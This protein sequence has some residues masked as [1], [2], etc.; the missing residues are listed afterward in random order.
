MGEEKSAYETEKPRAM[1][2]VERTG[3]EKEVNCQATQPG[4]AVGDAAGTL[5]GFG[6][7]LCELSCVKPGH[8]LLGASVSCVQMYELGWADL[9]ELS[10]LLYSRTSNTERMEV[11]PGL[12]NVEI[13]GAFGDRGFRRKDG[14]S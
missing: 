1:V 14:V 5:P 2:T 8:Q 12:G 10:M 7:L 9:L 6:I 11:S 13:L 4:A 3:L